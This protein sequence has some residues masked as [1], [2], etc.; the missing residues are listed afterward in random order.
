MIGPLT[1]GQWKPQKPLEQKRDRISS[2][3]E[4]PPQAQRETLKSARLEAREEA[5]GGDDK[6]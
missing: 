4:N 1:G 2:C 3:T 5:E 6:A